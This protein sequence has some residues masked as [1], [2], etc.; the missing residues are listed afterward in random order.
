MLLWVQQEDVR[1]EGMK[2]KVS[3]ETMYCVESVRVWER[4]GR[5]RREERCSFK[6]VQKRPG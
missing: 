6:V 4:K 2:Q 1:F 5:N 3:T